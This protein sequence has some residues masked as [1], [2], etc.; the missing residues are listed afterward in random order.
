[1]VPILILEGPDGSGKSTLSQMIQDELGYDV[2]PRVVSKQATAMTDLKKWVDDNLDEGLQPRI[3]DRHRLISETIYGPI[4]RESAN[5]GFDQLPWLGPRLRRFYNM[6]PLIIYCLPPL[7]EV[8]KN[9]ANDPDN[10]VVK[11]HIDQ[12]YSAYVARA[13]LDLE[14]APLTPLVW[15]YKASPTIQGKPAMLGKIKN[16]MDSLKEKNPLW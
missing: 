8:K 2:S 13:A 7:A 16:Y 1:M 6:K 4:L 3:Y 12:L 10:E 15:N 11:N 9:I 14:F 5:E